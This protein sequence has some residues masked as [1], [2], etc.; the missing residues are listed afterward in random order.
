MPKVI[1]DEK[2][3]NAVIDVLLASGYE[4]ATTIKISGA[5]GIH[6][7]TL[8][9]KYGNKLNII[10]KAI[11]AQFTDV[12][13]TQVTY[14]GDLRADLLAIIVAYIETSELV[15]DILPTLLLEIPSN[16]ELKESLETPWRNIFKI[17]EIL[18]QYQEQ[19]E[20]VK[21]PV[22][23]SLNVLIGPLMVMHMINKADLDMPIPTI[24]PPVYVD[25][26]LSGRA[27]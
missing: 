4:G 15:G 7:A 26:Y 8:F 20:L 10:Q 1:D 3:F 17:A 27:I 19:G 6:E 22:L 16:P 18:K 13:L 23:T 9:R 12:P 25:N 21:E 5:A 11:Q 24:D 2:V 14:T